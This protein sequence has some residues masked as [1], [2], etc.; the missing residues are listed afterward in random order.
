MVI[1]ADTRNMSR[2]TTFSYLS[3]VDSESAATNDAWEVTTTAL[4]RC[5]STS[6]DISPFLVANEWICGSLGQFLRLPIPPFAL[7]RNGHEK[8]MF[9]SLHF[10]GDAFPD[11][12]DPVECWRCLPDACTGVVLFDILI[13]NPDRHDGNL[14]TDLALAPTRIFVW[15]H[16]NA[17]FGVMPGDE[18]K[19]LVAKRDHFLITD[20]SGHC[21]LPLISHTEHFFPWILRIESLPNSFVRRVCHEI[22]GF[23]VTIEHA[24]AACE[25]LIH[26]KETLRNIVRNHKARFTNI[27]PHEWGFLI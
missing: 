14:R 27:Q 8:V 19:R 1:R 4:A 23:G 11:D 2:A 26:R 16:D 7:L 18:F 20:G 6:E 9:A 3:K 10:G 15:D 17:L 12:A 5:G 24:E 25:F 22:T 21:L 13:G